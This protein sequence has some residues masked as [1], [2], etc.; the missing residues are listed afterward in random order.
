M[1]PLI[2]SRHGMT[3]SSGAG[4]SLPLL[5][6][7]LLPMSARPADASSTFDVL[8]GRDAICLGEKKCELVA[9]G[10]LLRAAAD[11]RAKPFDEVAR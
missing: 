4:L 8:V 1:E 2:L 9:R 3:V 7:F 10:R 11:G 5:L 6:L